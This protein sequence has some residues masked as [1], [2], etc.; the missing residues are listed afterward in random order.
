MLPDQD[1]TSLLL[2]IQTSLFFPGRSLWVQKGV[3]TCKDLP[4]DYQKKSNLMVRLLSVTRSSKHLCHFVKDADYGSLLKIVKSSS[5]NM[6]KLFG[7]IQ[8]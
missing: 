2:D 8:K 4:H 6:Y 5:Q 1:K 3:W 7:N